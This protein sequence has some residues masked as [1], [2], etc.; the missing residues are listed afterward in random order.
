[1]APKWQNCQKT[2][3]ALLMLPVKIKTKNL[4]MFKHLNKTYGHDRF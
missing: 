3:H 4:S 1:M 2:L